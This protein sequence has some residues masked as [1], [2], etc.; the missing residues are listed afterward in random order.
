M[1]TLWYAVY[2]FRSDALEVITDQSS[3]GPGA[4]GAAAARASRSQRRGVRARRRAAAPA[5]ACGASTR[6]WPRRRSAV[7]LVD[8]ASLVL[9][10][11]FWRPYLFAVVPG[12]VLCAA[13]LLA[14]RD[15]VARRTERLVVAAV[16]V[17]LG[18]T[19]VWTVVGLRRRRPAGRDPHRA[20]AAPG[21]RARR[22]GRRVRRARR[23]GAGQRAA[24]AVPPPV[25]ACRC[26][27]STPTWPSCSN[28]LEG[29]DAPTWFILWV[30][31]SS[32]GGLAG[33]DHA[34]AAGALRAARRD[35]RRAPR[36]PA[37]GRAAARARPALRRSRVAR[38]GRPE[39][40]RS[41]RSSAGWQ[42]AHRHPDGD[43]VG[44]HP[45]P[46]AHTGGEHHRQHRLVVGAR[47]EHDLGR[48]EASRRGARTRRAAGCR[49][50]AG[51]RPGR[52]GAAPGARPG[53]SSGRSTARPDRD[54]VDD[55]GDGV[56][57][58]DVLRSGRRARPTPGTGS[59]ASRRALEDVG[60]QPGE[61]G[62]RGRARW[63]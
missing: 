3:A 52:P 46:A 60:D 27:P 40:R 48:T 23:A 32:W 28:L 5:A 19:A 41:G 31:E 1:H 51:A 12:V 26:A 43:H 25:D 58:G 6:C 14:V 45:D 59:P 15:H 17:S 55:R 13:L 56:G 18:G 34:G 4:A 33:A 57:L 42:V 20:G 37:R 11:S 61:R 36:L 49:C 8:T 50:R 44:R 47:G 22:H 39:R 30:P 2:G 54:A 21:G 10:G 53:S 38:A 16:V 7:V 62:A 24:L 63:P 35:L 29:P 9:S